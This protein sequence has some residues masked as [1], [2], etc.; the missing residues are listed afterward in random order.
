MSGVEI[1]NDRGRGAD[2]GLQTRAW[3]A[4]ENSMT[5]VLKAILLGKSKRP[6]TVMVTMNHKKMGRRRENIRIM[7][8]RSLVR[9]KE[10]KHAKGSM[11][12]IRVNIRR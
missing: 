3:M 12:S 8:Q 4:V 10:R 1:A 11:I 6:S 9:V 7:R 5:G 2:D